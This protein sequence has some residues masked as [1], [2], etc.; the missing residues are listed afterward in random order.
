MA[1]PLPHVRF[2]VVVGLM[3]SGKTTV[4][5]A[6]ASHLRWRFDDSDT[7][8]QAATG[9]TV[10]ELRDERGEPALR[11]AEAAHLLRALEGSSEVVIAAAAGVVEDDRC[12]A[13]LRGPGIQV[14]WL[15]ASPALLA[16]RFANEPHRPPYGDDPAAFLA[17]QD[18][19]RSPLYASLDPL[20]IDVDGR[21]ATETLATVAEAVERRRG[22]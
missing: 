2:I 6:L 7:A 9:L 17:R 3:A 5:R 15:R 13:A 10:R 14:V 20:A 21:T 22:R 8:I 4:G 11:E 12:L 16:A 19:L 18:A 1:E